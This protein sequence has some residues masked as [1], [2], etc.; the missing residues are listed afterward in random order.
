MPGG[1][2]LRR[3]ARLRDGQAARRRRPATAA[4]RAARLRL[5]RRPDRRTSRGCGTGS[6]TTSPGWRARARARVRAALKTRERAARADVGLTLL[7]PRRRTGSHRGRDHRQLRDLPG[8]LPCRCRRIARPRPTAGRSRCAASPRTG[9]GGE[10][11]QRMCT[12]PVPVRGVPGDHYTLFRRARPG[13]VVA[14]IEAETLRRPEET[15]SWTSDSPTISSG[16]GRTCGKM[17]RPA[18]PRR[19]G[20]GHRR[21][22]ADRTPRPLYRLLGELGL[23]AVHWPAEFGGAGRPPPMPPS[24]PRNWYA[25][26]CPTPCTSTPSR[27]SASSC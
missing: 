3:R 22:R 14:A 11:W 7:A 26:G 6:S 12:G 8:L 21:G 25:A 18:S 19:A 4:G 5:L 17:L 27:S 24:S 20:G 23:L 9:H 10:R 13:R 15:P 2:V 16:S 1:L